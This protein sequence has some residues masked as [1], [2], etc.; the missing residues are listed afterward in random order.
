MWILI[1]TQ[2]FV[3]GY[4]EKDKIRGLGEYG[5]S[6]SPAWY[7]TETKKTQKLFDKEGKPTQPK[8]NGKAVSIKDIDGNSLA[9]WNSIYNGWFDKIIITDL[10]NNF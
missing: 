7:N 4:S 6:K 3:V 5:R 8:V 2:G 9:I 10:K 1:D